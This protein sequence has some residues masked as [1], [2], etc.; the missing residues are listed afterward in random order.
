M[1]AARTI[2]NEPIPD[3][4]EARTKRVLS[5][6]AAGPAGNAK[7]TK[8]AKSL[9]CGGQPPLLTSEPASARSTPAVK[10]TKSP[11]E[12]KEPRPPAPATVKQEAKQTKSNA[13]KSDAV[14][15]TPDK[16]LLQGAKPVGTKAGKA[17]ATSTVGP[18][19][20]ASGPEAEK[21]KT[22]GRPRRVVDGM[23][24]VSTTVGAVS[25]PKKPA[26]KK[27]EGEVKPVPV[28]KKV[29][30]VAEPNPGLTAREAEKN[31]KP[32]VSAPTPA[33][34]KVG[35]KPPTR[36]QGPTV[37]SSRRVADSP[38]DKV[39]IAA[40]KQGKARKTTPS[41]LPEPARSKAVEGKPKPVGKGS[42]AAKSP[43]S[44]RPAGLPHPQPPLPRPAQASGGGRGGSGSKAAAPKRKPRK[45]PEHAVLYIARG[46]SPRG[47][48]DYE[49]PF[50]TRPQALA[51]LA[52]Q[53]GL[54]TEEVRKLAKGSSLRLKRQWH[55]SEACA[56]REI[57]M[58]PDEAQRALFGELS[59][60]S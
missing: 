40:P 43:V 28:V 13:K 57:R 27:P 51:F 24:A 1:N 58:T 3:T 33:S 32:K 22:V 21:A 36:G 35:S 6:F 56:V 29:R 50:P 16:S 18:V 41:S 54:T 48:P 17:R 19:S 8:P 26:S 20:N 44:K 53:H 42:K 38:K 52:N 23:S 39:P 55:G 15:A 11:S 47:A 37:K 10:K 7:G 30:A 60:G 45:K 46:G 12:P 2:G 14:A 34:A 5:A 31:T 59:R 4:N 25:A 9:D 49:V